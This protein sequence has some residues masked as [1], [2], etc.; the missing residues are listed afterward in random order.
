MANLRDKLQKT[1]G[2]ELFGLEEAMAKINMELLNPT[3]EKL[4]TVS[5]VTAQEIFPLT[6]LLTLSKRLNSTLME[7]WV[8]K[9]LLLR[10]SRFRLGRRE[11]VFISGGLREVSEARKTGQKGGL[12][13]IFSGFK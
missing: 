13:G 3:G 2:S 7:K 5:D 4:F 6:Y 12:A 9:F 10:I 8:E 1:E 11:F